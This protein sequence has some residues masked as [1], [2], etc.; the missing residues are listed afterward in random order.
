MFFLGGGDGGWVGS[1]IVKLR[2]RNQKLLIP[3]NAAMVAQW[4]GRGITARQ[5]PVLLLILRWVTVC[6]RRLRLFP[7]RLVMGDW[8]FGKR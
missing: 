8:G 3:G 7:P 5:A 6:L 4:M 2:I 1:N